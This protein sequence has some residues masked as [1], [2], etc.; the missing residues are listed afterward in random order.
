MQ[1]QSSVQFV[2]SL[3]VAYYGRPADPEGLTYWA[4]RAEE[5][6]YGAIIDAFGESEEFTENFGELNNDQLVDS[7]YQQLFSRGAEP[8]GLEFYSTMLEQGE[9][10]LAEIAVTILNAARG[11]DADAAE[12]KVDIAQ[13]YTDSVAP[14]SYDVAFAQA[15][16]TEV[17]GNTTPAEIEAIKEEVD[18]AVADPAPEDPEDPPVDEDSEDP[19]VDEDPEDPP[20]GED[21]EDPADPDPEDPDDR[22]IL[23]ISAGD[24]ELQTSFTAEDLEGYEAVR[25]NGFSSQ[26]FNFTG[27]ADTA[28][29]AQDSEDIVFNLNEM[30]AANIELDESNAVVYAEEE[31]DAVL[32]SLALTA[33]G[34]SSV[35]LGGS[36]ARGLS[37]VSVQ[38]SGDLDLAG[39]A[40]G[41]QVEDSATLDA[42]ALEGNLKIDDGALD[43]DQV[44]NVAT[45]AGDDVLVTDSLAIDVDAGAGDDTLVFTGTSFD[46]GEAGNIENVNTLAVQ[47][48]ARIDASAFED[49]EHFDFQSR[50]EIFNLADDQVVTVSDA[51]FDEAEG[52]TLRLVDAGENV[53]IATNF[54]QERTLQLTVNTEEAEGGGTLNLS[55][56]GG[57]TYGEAGHGFQQVDATELEG[58][59]DYTGAHFVQETVVL[60]DGGANL[61]VFRE[62]E[63]D[64]GTDIN[65]TSIWGNL[66]R[67]EN[68]DTARDSFVDGGEIVSFADFTDATDGA[69][70][71]DAAFEAVAEAVAADD[72]EY[73]A[74]VHGDNTY[75]YADTEVEGDN[76]GLSHNDFAIELTGVNVVD[77]LIG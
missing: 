48:W 52:A 75:L 54:E 46:Q 23:E 4:E 58:A 16:L 42:S 35:E 68:F 27:L 37:D 53:N 55:G 34:S 33:D 40:I 51:N 13:H 11:T 1:S 18:Q 73:A 45:G 7:L 20:V 31:G 25:F 12:A 17:D 39:A 65:P 47:N 32:S 30:A 76:V 21:P 3:Y 71:L 43:Q 61:S 59:L 63:R 41:S 49:V 19:P 9:K 8:E 70:D 56:N 10:T 77:E 72:A 66:G 26:T 74:F 67:V 62:R 22:E 57:V 5:E 14:D 36:A 64:D 50:G 15:K 60:G 69:D 6:G 38:G 28:L 29:I 24:E 2:Q 44:A